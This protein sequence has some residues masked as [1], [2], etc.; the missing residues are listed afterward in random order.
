[1]AKTIF[2]PSPSSPHGS[3]ASSELSIYNPTEVYEWEVVSSASEMLNDHDM[4]PPPVITTPSSDPPR[5]STPF[6]NDT[7]YHPKVPSQLREVQAAQIDV[8]LPLTGDEASNSEHPLLVTIPEANDDAVS[9]VSSTECLMS[10]I[11]M[12]EED[13]KPMK[14]TKTT[15]ASDDNGWA[16][17]AVTRWHTQMDNTTK[18]SSHQAEWEDPL[19]GYISNHSHKERIEE[20][21]K[22]RKAIAKPRKGTDMYQGTNATGAGIFADGPFHSPPSDPTAFF[23]KESDNQIFIHPTDNCDVLDLF[24]YGGSRY[25]EGKTVTLFKLAIS[26][27]IYSAAQSYVREF[28]SLIHQIKAYICG[29]RRFSEGVKIPESLLDRQHLMYNP[30]NGFPH[31]RYPLVKTLLAAIAARCGHPRLAHPFDRLTLDHLRHLVSL[32]FPV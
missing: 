29:D 28:G 23:P 30:H 13:E 3:T 15:T 25:K 21:Y 17:A 26:P 20:A 2:D 18:T 4:E 27:V 10:N 24:A 8:E 11:Y 12:D 6:P 14:K 32:R 22:V 19:Q 7:R 5:T 16:S 9:V 31:Y 1:M